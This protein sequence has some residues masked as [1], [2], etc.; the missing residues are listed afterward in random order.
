MER[1]ID[2][3]FAKWPFRSQFFETEGNSHSNGETER[4]RRCQ[5]LAGSLGGLESSWQGC[6]DNR[7]K[8][9]AGTV[10]HGGDAE[11]LNAEWGNKKNI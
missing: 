3:T 1:L 8:L 11:I 7:L 5:T 6:F 2:F 4:N 9:K 10:P